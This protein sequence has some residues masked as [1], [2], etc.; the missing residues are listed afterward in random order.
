MS[1][2]Y[3]QMIQ[4]KVKC[5]HKR[6]NKNRTEYIQLQNL[7]NKILQT[8]ILLPQILK[9]NHLHLMSRFYVCIGIV[10]QLLDLTASLTLSQP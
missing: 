6:E 1:P 2:I 5:V 10:S 4:E 3:F 8:P 7:C 9:T